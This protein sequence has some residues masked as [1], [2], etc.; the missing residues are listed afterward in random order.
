M[1]AIINTRRN[2][3]GPCKFLNNYLLTYLFERDRDSSRHSKREQEQGGEGEA[4]S[5]LRTEADM[6]L[7][8]RD[9]GITT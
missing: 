8:P 2:P 9:P 4:G 6:G 3:A 7:D 1:H 5:P